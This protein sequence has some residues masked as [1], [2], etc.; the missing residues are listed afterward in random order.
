MKSIHVVGLPH[1]A[2]DGE[3]TVPWCAYSNKALRFIKMMRGLGWTVHVYEGKR[4][5]DKIIEKTE[6][7]NVPT[8][9]HS[10]PWWEQMHK[11]VVPDI[12][13]Q[14]NDGDILACLMS[15]QESLA[16][17][18]KNPGMGR[19]GK[20]VIPVEIGVGYERITAQYA[21]FESSEWQAFVYASLQFTGKC[22]SSSIASLRMLDAIIPNAYSAD[23]FAE[24][25]SIE[26]RKD[27][28]GKRYV[29]SVCRKDAAK[30]ILECISMVQKMRLKLKED[31]HLK[32]VGPG[33]LKSNFERAQLD[34]EKLDEAW[35]EDIG[36]VAG[37]VK[38]QIF[39]NASLF[40]LMTQYVAP[41][42]GAHV[43]A[44]LSGVPCIVSNNGIYHTTSSISGGTIAP[45][46]YCS[47]E[48]TET[49]IRLYKSCTNESLR[50]SADKLIKWCGTDVVAQQYD[51]WIKRII[52]FE[53]TGGKTNNSKRWRE[54]LEV[55]EETLS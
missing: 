19:K 38:K 3:N 6:F 49:A 24:F 27:S 50:K 45:V 13:K 43:E 11:K 36:I 39:A 35:I 16:I 37:E 51:A 4:Y 33:N 21:A 23:E 25:I 12:A 1:I 54:P 22:H 53:E 20:K 47:D 15:T 55:L 40:V 31:I 32:I 46:S 29:L 7:I 2:L 14:A 52:S 48:A 8:W 28:S 41:F 30:G 18:I 42:E 10:D 34:P 26:D 5:S 44:A 9:E 17:R